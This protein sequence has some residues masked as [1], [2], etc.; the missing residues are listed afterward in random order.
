MSTRILELFAGKSVM[1]RS[2]VDQ[3]SDREFE[4]FRLLGQGLSKHEIGKRF[5]MSAKTV[6]SH[7]ANTKKKL[8]M[9]T[10]SELIS[11][12]ASWAA[13]EANGRSR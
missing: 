12:S 6:D 3:L 2:G 10:T 11:Y 9:K 7:R 1:K 8:D 5:Q 4:V 13:H